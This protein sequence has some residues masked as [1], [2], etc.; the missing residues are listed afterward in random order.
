MEEDCNQNF[1]NKPNV[2]QSILGYQFFGRASLG[3]E[4]NVTYANVPLVISKQYF[5]CHDQRIGV[6]GFGH[7]PNMPFIILCLKK[8]IDFIFMCVLLVF[9]CPS[10]D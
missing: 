3:S 6:V 8:N 10:F 1:G 7:Q 2:E 4:P 5:F 9:V